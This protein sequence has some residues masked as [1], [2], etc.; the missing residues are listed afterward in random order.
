MESWQF[1]G[2]DWD[3]TPYTTE[4]FKDQQ[5][6][7][8]RVK[9][10]SFDGGTTDE[11]N[12]EA[13]GKSARSYIRRVQAWLRVTKLPP[14]HRALA[15]YDALS[16]K[17]WVVAEELDLDVLS[18]SHG[19]PCF[20]EWVQTRFMDVEVNKISQLMTDL[21]RRCKRRPEQSVREFNVE[22]ERMV[23]RLHEIRCELPP[24]VK[25]WL[26]VDKL[27]LSESEELALLASVGNEYDVRRLQHAAL[28]QDR[29]L[30]HRGPG[31]NDHVKS[32]G[33]RP[34][35][36]QSVH[37]TVDGAT[38]DE[39]EK[40]DSETSVLVDEETAQAEHVA[41]MTY[42]GA[43]A[44][45]R[46]S[47]RG[48]GTD[49][50]ELKRRSE[51][52][53]RLAKQ[54]SYCSAC[55]R[56]GHWH[57]DPECPLK[58]QRTT[59]TTANV[60]GQVQQ[61]QVCHTVQEC[62]M[63]AYEDTSFPES[64]MGG[65]S[66][67]KGMLA[68]VDTACTKSVAGYRWFEA[69]VEEAE[70]RKHPYEIVDE[71]EH[72]RFGASRV[73]KSTF[74]IWAWFGIAHHWVAVK[75]QVVHRI[76]HGPCLMPTSSTLATPWKMRKEDII[77][78][79]ENT[80]NL[81]VN[82]RWLLPE[83]RAMLIEAR[84]GSQHPEASNDPMKGITKLSVAELK[85]QAKKEGIPVPSKATKGWL[86]HQLRESRSTPADTVVPFGKFK[87]WLYREVPPGYLRWAVAEAKEKADE[88]HPDLRRLANWAKEEL[89]RVA[90]T[91][92]A[93]RALVKDPEA[94]ASVPVPT[95]EELSEG[96]S[97][98]SAWSRV[99]PPRKGGG[100]HED[101]DLEDGHVFLCDTFEDPEDY[102]AASEDD[103]A[104]KAL[105]T[106]DKEGG[107]A[108]MFEDIYEIPFGDEHAEKELFVTQH[109]SPRERAIAGIRHRKRM[110]ENTQKRLR[111]HVNS[112]AQVLMAC[113]AR[114]LVKWGL[115][116]KQ[117]IEDVKGV[118]GLS[119]SP[120]LWWMKLSQDLCSISIQ[121]K[122]RAISV[123]HNPI[124]P[125]VFMLI[126]GEKQETL[127][128][129]LTHVDDLMLLAE[130]DLSVL[131]RKELDARFPVDEWQEG[132]FEYVG[133]EYK[134]SNQEI[135]VSQK[136]YT[137]SRVTKVD[138]K[139]G[140]VG[141]EEIEE[142]RTSI[143]SLSWLSKQ[144]RPDLQFYVSQAQKK[145]ND[146]T[147]EDLKFTNKAVSLATKHGGEGVHL[148]KIDEDKLIFLA[149]H[150]AAWGNADLEDSFDPTW[151]GTHQVASQIGSLILI[152]DRGCLGSPG[153]K[154]S[155]IDWKSKGCRRV[156]RS[157][158]AGETMACCEAMESGT[159]LRALFLSFVHGK[160]IPEEACGE[161]VDLHMVTDCKSLFDHIHREGVP[162]A[163]TEKRLAIDLASVRQTL[164]REAAHQ[165]GDT[166]DFL[167][168]MAPMDVAPRPFT[169]PQQIVCRPSVNPTLR[170]VHTG[171][172]RLRPVECAVA[173]AWGVSVL[174]R[175]R[176]RRHRHAAPDGKT[177]SE[178][179]GAEE[180]GRAEPPA[181]NDRD[182]DHQFTA[183][184][185]AYTAAYFSPHRRFWR[186]ARWRLQGEQGAF[187]LI[188]FARTLAADLQAE[189]K[190]TPAID[191]CS[192][193]SAASR[194]CIAFAMALPSGDHLAVLHT[195]GG[196]D[197][198]ELA[199]LQPYGSRAV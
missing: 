76:R 188:A 82:R 160:I 120:K 173:S 49:P 30:R 85:E 136:G 22:F 79:L 179:S 95:L 159:F 146:P 189:A 105:R 28:V 57:K 61:A 142:N 149:Y 45:Y 164:V 81:P 100:D 177:S 165:G 60:S 138:V 3:G 2:R 8:E 115:R 18:T 114:G 186:W 154:F 107:H 42:Q 54:R 55:K 198:G 24:L 89:E 116:P 141:R 70:I 171:R 35:W 99:S 34:R 14:A 94:L 184:F 64:P 119:T 150:D 124:D 52:R 101:D 104:A 48:R 111:R 148:R 25:A 71:I 174:R 77:K 199:D 6:P 168:R 125:C 38:S 37:M 50:D 51:E 13:V 191:C 162:K 12:P 19:V 73:H 108:Y 143:G 7:T 197:G 137:E 58:G 194:S 117:L 144:T 84:K 145:Q 53:L 36:R 103:G 109:L 83:V 123:E 15:L 147:L 91:N 158:F 180:G 27:R 113:S 46:E 11:S 126:D 16:D 20:L 88:A 72:F 196:F 96:Q 118:F 134:V 183:A 176:G 69:F 87:G 193:I 152:A 135:F 157:T 26:Y 172:P 9:V 62:Y 67:E 192:G 133:C 175:T 65:L 33:N 195:A 190:H 41:Y 187:D 139:R 5:K 106:E 155:L 112:L 44:K 163:P 66:A 78:E 86:I 102:E 32:S 131:M 68:I 29:T 185:N 153:G 161:F 132:E 181:P 39:E 75:V 156:C 122:G 23:L 93:T 74:A 4:A 10:P 130:K 63:T 80:Y 56:R 129:L 1:P 182:V 110:G 31:G 178:P 140:E 151:T 170:R 121:Y 40:A 98:A 21:F 97:S 90:Q 166:G 59:T 167:F 169:A 128:L 17:A 43:K 92:P 127:G 47:L